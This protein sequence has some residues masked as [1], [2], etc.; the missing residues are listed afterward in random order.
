MAKRI[1]FV[2]CVFWVKNSS[3]TIPLTFITTTVNL[4]FILHARPF[5]DEV[6]N[7]FEIFNELVTSYFLVM[8]LALQNDYYLSNNMDDSNTWIV[9]SVLWV[10]LLVH[11]TY[12]II[13]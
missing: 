11:L 4:A 3:M 9:I 12:Q 13:D 5:K 8:L 1:F 2:F 6:V 7:R 10:Y